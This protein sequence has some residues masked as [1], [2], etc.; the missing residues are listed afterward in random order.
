[1]RLETPGPSP[2]LRD[3][4]GTFRSVSVVQL[5]FNAKVESSERIVNGTLRT[6]PARK[7][8]N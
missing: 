7:V 4:I 8:E 1:M 5:G 3:A 6:K 2:K